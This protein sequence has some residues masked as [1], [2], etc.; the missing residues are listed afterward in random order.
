VKVSSVKMSSS[1]RLLK[2]RLLPSRSGMTDTSGAGNIPGPI[3]T[4]RMRPP[5]MA[6]TVPK[7]VKQNEIERV[8]TQRVWKKSYLHE[9]SLEHVS[10]NQDILE[11]VSLW[12]RRVHAPPVVGEDIEYAQND[13]KE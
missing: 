10:S 3:L 2:D 13:D 8:Y 4:S 5:T 7:S 6:K 12:M 1:F 11:E 9:I